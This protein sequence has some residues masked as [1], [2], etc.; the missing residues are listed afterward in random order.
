MTPTIDLFH[1]LDCVDD[2]Y[3]AITDY[4]GDI[5]QTRI[6]TPEGECFGGTRTLNEASRAANIRNI[7]KWR[8]RYEGHQI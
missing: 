8:K 2:G 6:Y 4:T 3:V 5:P 7:I 1:H